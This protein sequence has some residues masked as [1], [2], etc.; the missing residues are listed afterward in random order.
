MR[1]QDTF[2]RT[3]RWSLTRDGLLY[4]FYSFV[5]IVTGLT[6]MRITGSVFAGACAGALIDTVFASPRKSPGIVQGIACDA[7]HA[8]LYPEQANMVDFRDRNYDRLVVYT[9]PLFSFVD[10]LIGFWLLT[11]IGNIMTGLRVR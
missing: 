2:G 8:A 4:Y 3:W 11:H 9:R 7:L 6:F 10:Y 1:M 5:A